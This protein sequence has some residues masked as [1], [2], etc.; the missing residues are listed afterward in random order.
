MIRFGLYFDTAILLQDLR[1]HFGTEFRF[2]SAVAGGKA[3]VF[4]SV[5]VSPSFKFDSVCPLINRVNAAVDIEG[6]CSRQSEGTDQIEAGDIAKRKV[7]GRNSEKLFQRLRV[8]SR[9][10]AELES[11][12]LC[13]E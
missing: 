13:H 11:S 7:G 10:S 2:R 4:R 5:E 8:V 1:E 6:F 12:H 3:R 9:I